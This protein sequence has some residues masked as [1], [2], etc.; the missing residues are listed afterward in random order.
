MNRWHWAVERQSGRNWSQT[1]GPLS[2]LLRVATPLGSTRQA[3]DLQPPPGWR[4]PAYLRRLRSGD[5][6]RGV[7]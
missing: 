7:T 2:R 5:R 6:V 3:L 4:A 1:L